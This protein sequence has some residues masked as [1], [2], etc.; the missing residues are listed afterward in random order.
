M[1][2]R[3]STISCCCLS[4]LP[5]LPF[6]LRT[7]RIARS[8]HLSIILSLAIITHSLSLTH[9]LYLSIYILTSTIDYRAVPAAEHADLHPQDLAQGDRVCPLIWRPHVEDMEVRK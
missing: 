3:K 2:N 4:C 7:D 8:F 6:S 5:G 9:T 1:H